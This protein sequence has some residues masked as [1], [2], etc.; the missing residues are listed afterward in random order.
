[1]LLKLE[2]AVPKI[3]AKSFSSAIQLSLSQNS[4]FWWPSAEKR[5][6]STACTV[7]EDDQHSILSETKYFRFKI[8]HH[9]M[10]VLTFI[11]Y[12]QCFRWKLKNLCNKWL[13]YLFN[14]MSSSWISPSPHLLFLAALILGNNRWLITEKNWVSVTK[15]FY[16]S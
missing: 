6:R 1:V 3:F 4:N 11:M 14:W 8:S 7:P 15:L 2:S 10:L 13:N 12:R 16:I 9:K 5:L